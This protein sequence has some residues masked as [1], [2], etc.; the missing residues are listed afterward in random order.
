MVGMRA[1]VSSSGWI[2]SE[3]NKIACVV[4]SFTVTT[5][6]IMWYRSYCSERAS[7]VWS[8]TDEFRNSSSASP[9]RTPSNSLQ[10]SLDPS[11]TRHTSSSVSPASPAWLA[12]VA[13]RFAFWVSQ[14]VRRINQ[15]L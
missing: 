4:V 5:A 6:S 14:A 11:A 7:H 10:P 2:P 12:C 13:Q 8:V 1:V 9:T 3:L 15:D